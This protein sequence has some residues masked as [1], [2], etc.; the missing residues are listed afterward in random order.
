MGN[1]DNKEGTDGKDAATPAED[2]NWSPPSAAARHH[3]HILMSE[4]PEL[5]PHWLWQGRIPLRAITILDGD[6]G[7]GKSLMT[8]DLIAR[9]TTGRPMPDGTPGA[10]GTE[11][12]NALLLTAEDDLTTTIRPRLRAAGANLAQVAWLN[13][14]LYWKDGR[15]EKNYYTRCAGFRRSNPGPRSVRSSGTVVTDLRRAPRWTWMT[16]LSPSFAGLTRPCRR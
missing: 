15:D 9:V 14:A 2:F 12:A 8:L 4:I 5:K 7:L 1:M 11:S 16:S 3:L 13:E 10:F 6:P